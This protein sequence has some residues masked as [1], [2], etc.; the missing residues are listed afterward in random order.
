MLHTALLTS[1]ANTGFA[2]SSQRA[3]EVAAL[4]PATPASGLWLLDVALEAC[5]LT[6]A[7]LLCSAPALTVSSASV[8]SLAGICWQAPQT[9]LST[10]ASYQLEAAWVASYL[11]GTYQL[12][13]TSALPRA[14][15]L[16]ESCDAWLLVAELAAV[17][18]GVLVVMVGGG[19]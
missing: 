8:P 10:A 2:V 7:G 12:G 9:Q 13:F 1:I 6:Q 3:F 4:T 17:S 16:I 14:S 15:A 19:L 5:L 11:M 18:W